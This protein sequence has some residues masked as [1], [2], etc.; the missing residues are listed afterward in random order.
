[1]AKGDAI[2][3]KITSLTELF[4]F[5]ALFLLFQIKFSGSVF[6]SRRDQRR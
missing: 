5:N 6:I 3:I 4:I 2:G 1:M